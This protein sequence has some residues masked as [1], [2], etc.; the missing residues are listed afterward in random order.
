MSDTNKE[1]ATK[2]LESAREVLRLEGEHKEA[3]AKFLKLLETPSVV[4]PGPYVQDLAWEQGH[5][6]A[7]MV[8]T[9]NTHVKLLQNAKAWIRS[10]ISPGDERDIIEGLAKIVKENSIAVPFH[11]EFVQHFSDILK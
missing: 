11:K 5:E 2:L 7:Q 6:R 9:I 4:Q 10:G 1:H 8:A 3:L